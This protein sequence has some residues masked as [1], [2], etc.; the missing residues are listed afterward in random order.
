MNTANLQLEG[1][2][3]A[4]SAILDALRSKGAISGAEIETVLA[5]AEDAVRGDARRPDEMSDA[6]VEAICFPIRY[7][8]AANRLS[9]GGPVSAFS[10]I[11]TGVGQERRAR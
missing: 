8:R 5:A 3:V 2:C 7:L 6:N 9:D 1:V 11:A 4:L 10:R